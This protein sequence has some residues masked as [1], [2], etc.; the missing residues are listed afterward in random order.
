MIFII[1]KYLI[2]YVYI[3]IINILI[4]IINIINIIIII[5][6]IINFLISKTLL[7]TSLKKKQSLVKMCWRSYLTMPRIATE[8]SCC[9]KTWQSWDFW[10]TNLKSFIDTSCNTSWFYPSVTYTEAFIY[11]LVGDYYLFPAVELLFLLSIRVAFIS[12]WS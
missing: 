3:I 11:L 4:I 5:L 12:Q 9:I 8:S 2:I 6:I 1:N 7:Q 10:P